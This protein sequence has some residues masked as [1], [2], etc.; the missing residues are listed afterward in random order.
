MANVNIACLEA[1]S[2]VYWHS[3]TQQVKL[4][5]LNKI[6]PISALSDY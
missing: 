5:G 6:K 1:L 3:N 2:N 4:V